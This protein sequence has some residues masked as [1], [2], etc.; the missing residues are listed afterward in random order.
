[1]P[2]T[3]KPP[4]PG[5]GDN[6]THIFD[7]DGKEYKVRASL[8]ANVTEI[9]RAMIE[10]E[11]WEGVE[12]LL[13][14]KPQG[15]D[16][17]FLCPWRTTGALHDLV[18]IK[19]AEMTEGEKQAWHERRAGLITQY[20]GKGFDANAENFLLKERPLHVLLRNSPSVEE[21]KA[22]TDPGLG[23]LAA[24]VN[25]VEACKI[26]EKRKLKKCEMTPL[27]AAMKIKDGTLKKAV[28]EYL[29]ERGADS[30]IEGFDPDLKKKTKPYDYA[31]EAN[32]RQLLRLCVKYGA[33]ASAFLEP[34]KG[35]ESKEI[36]QDIEEYKA[37]HRLAERIVGVFCRERIRNLSDSGKE[38]LSRPL[39]GPLA[40][41]LFNACAE[42]S[43]NFTAALGVS[44]EETLSSLEAV[45]KFLNKN[46]E[47]FA[48]EPFVTA[49]LDGLELT[50]K[51]FVEK[52]SVT[53]NP[54]RN[55]FDGKTS[56][57]KVE[58]C[59][60]DMDAIVA[61]AVQKGVFVD[62]TQA[63]YE[64][65]LGSCQT[66]QA[67]QD[68]ITQLERMDGGSW[69]SLRN[70][71]PGKNLF[72]A[73][74]ETTCPEGPN[75]AAW[76]KN[77]ADI[78]RVCAGRDVRAEGRK[79]FDKD[80]KLPLQTLVSCGGTLEEVEA[81]LGD[82]KEDVALFINA[83]EN[84]V[85]PHGLH[86]NLNRYD[87]PLH[88]LVRNRRDEDKEAVKILE[89]LCEQGADVDKT[90]YQKQAS[91]IAWSEGKTSMGEA[92]AKHGAKTKAPKESASG[93][94]AP[95]LLN[96]YKKKVYNRLGKVAASL[97][98]AVYEDFKK[99]SGGVGNAAEEFTK[100]EIRKCIFGGL[101]R[102]V[103]MEDHH[104][105]HGFVKAME[106]SPLEIAGGNASKINTDRVAILDGINIGGNEKPYEGI[107]L[108]ELQ[109]KEEYGRKENEILGGFDPKVYVYDLL[110]LAAYLK[111]VSVMPGDAVLSGRRTAKQN[112]FKQHTFLQSLL[113]GLTKDP[114]P[115]ADVETYGTPPEEALVSTEQD[116]TVYTATVV[117]GAVTPPDAVA[118]FSPDRMREWQ[119]LLSSG[120]KAP[121][122]DIVDKREEKIGQSCRIVKDA[123][124]AAA[125]IGR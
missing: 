11:N 122:R 76:H 73:V 51:L 115:N 91:Q 87:P 120:K 20:V 56:V 18:R 22:L 26:W 95:E 125:G 40:T 59:Q 65:I 44:Q 39:C 106:S 78:L 81:F 47:S 60:D 70:Y 123:V 113:A 99:E 63:L 49:V 112:M 1:M 121:F 96:R 41:S 50:E 119:A 28:A 71:W 64:R 111:A 108:L 48:K 30:N 117:S 74:A 79:K 8:N 24:D 66:G 104:A 116:E 105:L 14:A 61:G 90:D 110:N 32:D 27:H 101:A 83:Q 124:A 5:T 58:V 13:T 2:I 9:A 7:V 84:R 36:R 4:Q 35:K 43:D 80:G 118:P 68:L 33:D 6:V 77:K 46:E 92:L 75:L 109:E 57:E 52:R 86:L 103:D 10:D 89:F 42:K 38:K 67:D 88:A 62:G 34:L 19:P 37:F 94:D 17:P 97:A 31:I 12:E 69:I 55:L 72:H 102:S 82:R 45:S 23:N 29:F 54:L 3:I 114:T 16:R 85:V 107:S 25:A 93:L 98:D 15:D 100:M 21:I 53:K